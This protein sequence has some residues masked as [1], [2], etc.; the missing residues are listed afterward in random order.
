M[1]PVLIGGICFWMLVVE[2]IPPDA[3][4]HSPHPVL[5]KISHG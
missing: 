4:A 5:D 1:L 3:L 2:T